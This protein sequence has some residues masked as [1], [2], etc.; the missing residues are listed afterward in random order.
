MGKPHGRSLAFKPF[1]SLPL[2][3][4]ARVVRKKPDSGSIFESQ[5]DGFDVSPPIEGIR[6]DMEDT[7][8]GCR[9]Q[10]SFHGGAPPAQQP[11]SGP[12]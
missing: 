6:P 7:P 10:E 2:L 8:S 12:P 11:S 3:L 5:L 1:E 4:S 9:G